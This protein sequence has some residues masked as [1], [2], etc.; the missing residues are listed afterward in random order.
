MLSQMTEKVENMEESHFTGHTY[1]LRDLVSTKKC[2]F[3][4]H[5][6]VKISAKF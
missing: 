2:I 5:L 3:F 1:A 4:I 6:G